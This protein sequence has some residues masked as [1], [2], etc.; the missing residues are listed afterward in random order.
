VGLKQD[1]KLRKINIRYSF[2]FLK[3]IIDFYS[4]DTY[5]KL[6]VIT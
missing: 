3:G 5:I 1:I 2:V 6:V 4:G